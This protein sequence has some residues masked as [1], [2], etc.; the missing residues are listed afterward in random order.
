MKKNKKV[1]Q[2]KCLYCEMLIAMPKVRG[3]RY[4]KWGVIHTKHKVK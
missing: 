4:V 3:V 2:V 1:I